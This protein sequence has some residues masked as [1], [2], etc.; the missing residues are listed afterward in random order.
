MLKVGE[1]Y[2]YLGIDNSHQA[3]PQNP[4]TDILRSAVYSA[5]EFESYG[6]DD[7][8]VE[9]C[10][11]SGTS[12]P[13]DHPGHYD[14]KSVDDSETLTLMGFKGALHVSFATT[15]PNFFF[16]QGMLYPTI[17]GKFDV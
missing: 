11:D 6:T 9:A 3:D 8:E 1:L 10:V 13:G 17:E 5:A 14:K 15:P 2:S 12:V 16:N 4:N 7:G